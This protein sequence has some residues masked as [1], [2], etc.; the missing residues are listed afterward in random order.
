M[1]E[2]KPV[3]KL[4]G[5]GLNKV[6]ISFESVKDMTL[7]ELYGLNPVPI[8]ALTKTLWALIKDEKLVIKQPPTE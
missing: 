2:E 5:N 6:R 7:G 1:K 8:T 4:R 3:K